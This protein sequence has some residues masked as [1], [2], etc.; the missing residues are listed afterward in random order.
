MIFLH[1]PPIIISKADFVLFL[2]HLA[3]LAILPF[4]LNS[5]LDPLNLCL[6]DILIYI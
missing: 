6:I 2:C 4:W 1:F 3:D 5:D